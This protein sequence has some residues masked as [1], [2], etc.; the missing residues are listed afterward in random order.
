MKQSS[1]PDSEIRSGEVT[2]VWSRRRFLGGTLVAAAAAP[3]GALA[4]DAAPAP[5]APAKPVEFS[6]KI[7]VGIIGGG[8]RGNFVG[9]FMKQHGGYEVHAVADYFP[10]LAEKLGKAFGVDAS[11]RFTGLSGYK[12]VI[13]SG[14]EA[15][16]ITDVPYFYAEQATA[17]VA[18]GLHVYMAKPV[19]VDVPGC[20]AVEAAYKAAT[21]KQRC[22]LVD[23]QIPHDPAN[24]EVA[25]RVQAGALGRLTHL[26]SFGCVSAWND[27]PKGPTIES[28]L[29]SG[30]WLSD[31]ALGGDSI[32]SYD[33][34]MIDGITWLMKKR[35]VGAY[36]RS[37]IVR[38][39]PHGDRID[40]CG[41]V[42][43]YDD[44]VIWTH[45]L[46]CMNNNSDWSSLSASVFGTA[47]M[48][49]FG[50]WTK[51]YVRGGDKSYAGQVSGAIYNEG[52]QRNVADFYQCITEGRF[53]NVTAARAVDGHLACI[54][55]REASARGRYLTMD[56]LIKENKKL[57]VDLSGLK[58]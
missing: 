20:L 54:L 12:K 38:P 18:A 42:Y 13:E 51:A 37:R 14:V 22:F 23:F 2:A 39:Q 31:I 27:P 19:A 50:Y 36:G 57:E 45:V 10:D 44:G 5:A 28:R 41:V 21:A 24:I 43:D 33:I 4:A 6:R 40:V 17:A 8:H 47:A 48:A 58:A 29:K 25:T 11:R 26:L 16:L 56:E 9:G 32:V 34:H 53:E 52:A 3:L 49:H 7:K 35:P 46:Q 55:G 15:L 1:Q 30:V